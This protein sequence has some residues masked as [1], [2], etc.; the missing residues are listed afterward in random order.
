MKDALMLFDGSVVSYESL[1]FKSDFDPHD[2]FIEFFDDYYY[3]FIIDNVN[4]E[5]NCK[6]RVRR[7]RSFAGINYMAIF[8]QSGGKFWGYYAE[9]NF[10]NFNYNVINSTVSPRKGLGLPW[11]Y[12]EDTIHEDFN[13]FMG[14]S[15]IKIESG[16]IKR[17]LKHKQ[18]RSDEAT[19]NNNTTYDTLQANVV[20]SEICDLSAEMIDYR[21]FAIN[22]KLLYFV[23]D[24]STLT[25]IV[26]P[27][28]MNS[29]IDE[30]VYQLSEIILDINLINKLESVNVWLLYNNHIR[31]HSDAIYSHNYDQIDPNY[32][33]YFTEEYY[34]TFRLKL[35]E[36]VNWLRGFDRDYSDC[37]EDDLIFRTIRLFSI[38]ELRI[39]PI[40]LKISWLKKI[41]DNN[42]FLIGDWYVNELNEES[43]VLK[44]I[45]SIAYKDQNNIWNT[46]EI[47]IFLDYLIEPYNGTSDDTVFEK[48]YYSIDDNQ[49]IEE[50][51]TGNCAKLMNEIYKLWLLSSYNIDTI[52]DHNPESS[53]I[54]AYYEDM[55]DKPLILDY[56]LKK[57]WSL[58]NDSFLFSFMSTEIGVYKGKNE[59]YQH[60]GSY[61]VYKA[62]LIPKFQSKDSSIGLSEVSVY[63]DYAKVPL[64]YLK[65][66]DDYNANENTLQI[67]ETGFD[68]ALTFTGIGN[69]TKLRH[70]RHFTTLGRIALGRQV[71]PA[72]KIL[73]WEAVA[74]FSAAVDI[75]ASI[76]SMIIT[77]YMEGCSVYIDGDSSAP[78]D[79]PE[80]NGINDLVND[81]TPN[82]EIPVQSNNP[83][84]EKC[85]TLDRWLF[86]AQLASAGLDII[87]SQMVR[88][89]SR[90]LVDDDVLD[91]MLLEA[92][93]QIENA[94]ANLDEL[95]STLQT[96]LD[97]LL[98]TNSQLMNDI[99][100][101]LVNE[102]EKLE[103]LLH[104]ANQSDE[105]IIRLSSTIGN[106]VESSLIR[107]WSEISPEIRR[108]RGDISLLEEIR[109]MRNSARVNGH[110]IPLDVRLWS[111]G[112]MSVGGGHSWSGAH[113]KVGSYIPPGNTHQITSVA[114]EDFDVQIVYEGG[115]R[116]GKLTITTSS[117]HPNNVRVKEDHTFFP[118]DW[119]DQRISEEIAYAHANWKSNNP[120]L[121]L[122]YNGGVNMTMSDNTTLFV[123]FRDG[124][125]ITCYPIPTIKIF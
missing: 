82:P 122:P 112:S 22:K 116:R 1:T 4:V 92:R 106:D 11:Y 8:S 43:L 81:Q 60:I 13:L 64:F 68:V 17:S 32:H 45:S 111:N 42:Y 78:Q 88:R 53:E 18:V 41:I 69:I 10:W 63:G 56:A 20:S 27:S 70:F 26:E 6:G 80:H 5:V 46:S 62:V 9:D 39:A 97:E 72:A 91:G 125:L 101:L 87:A 38:Q 75:T 48:L 65:Y 119:T 114:F 58:H 93:Q 66:I 124:N 121:S 67:I 61:N 71:A 74:G 123:A 98:G 24:Q 3:S 28:S 19:I 59:E 55:K 100:S 90:K 16:S 115:Y 118:D 77:Y 51:G 36:L 34:F 85:K 35:I 86:W 73:A 7:F 21:D 110:V 25:P 117:P 49:A 50:P 54:T 23:D 14:N 31:R 84:Y 30:I 104:F 94:A 52:L 89:L 2:D 29:A 95:R 37:S 12:L 33:P 102:D 105:D 109:L 113:N 107:E 108:F 76:G 57:S 44:L 120:G 15:T 103:F 79:S 83:S 47:R 40:E 99:D 96:R